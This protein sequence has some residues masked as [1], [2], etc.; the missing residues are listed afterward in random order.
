M[1]DKLQRLTDFIVAMT[2]AG[3]V[4]FVT[5]EEVAEGCAMTTVGHDVEVHLMLK[6]CTDVSII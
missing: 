3:H 2:N 4:Q 5:T 1:K 6:V